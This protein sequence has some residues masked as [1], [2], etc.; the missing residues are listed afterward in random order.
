MKGRFSL[1][2]ILHNNRLIM[3]LSLIAAIVLWASVVYGSSSNEKRNIHMGTYT[4]SFADNSYAKE[5]G[6]SIIQGGEVDVQVEVS[7]PRFRINQAQSEI[8]VSADLSSIVRPGTYKIPLTATGA[9]D[10]TIDAINP[11]SVTVVADYVLSKS[12]LLT[13]DVSAVTVPEGDHYRLGSAMLDTSVVSD[14]STIEIEGPQTVLERIESVVARVSEGKT[15]EKA[16]VFPAELAALDANGNA[17]DTTLCS[18]LDK[19]GNDI[20]SL[21]LTVPVSVS[22]EVPVTYSVENLPS[23]YRTDTSFIS[24]SPSTVTLWGRRSPWKIMRWI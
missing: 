7:G 18:F 5:T 23:A 6:L 16:T 4:L 14:D 20:K 1:N 19:N 17:V 21:N 24:L 22:K 13:T 10:Y 15:I 8:S 2:R 9:S 12:V 11:S 3:V